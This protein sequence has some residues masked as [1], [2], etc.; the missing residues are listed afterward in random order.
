MVAFNRYGAIAA[1]IYDIDKPVGALPDTALYLARLAGLDGPVLEP[2]CGSGRTLLPLLQAGLN[3]TG[4]D[5]SPNMLDRCRDRCASAGFAPDLSRQSFDDFTYDQRFAAIVVPIAS[6]TL[7]DTFD[8]ALAALRRFHHH[9]QPGGRL[10]VDIQPLAFLASQS[11]D[12]RRWTNAAGEQL[13]C[14]GVRV[15]TDWFTQRAETDYRYER[16]QDGCLIE[17]QRDPMAQRYWGVEEFRLALAAT[18]FSEIA[19]IGSYDASRP[20]RPT[21]RILTFDAVRDG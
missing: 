13:T 12:R 10:L 21:D 7:V 8:A 3:A 19:A 9:L 5:T 2:A 20:P 6:F 16:W 1:E 14:E 15:A 17:T 18:G 4:F 11:V